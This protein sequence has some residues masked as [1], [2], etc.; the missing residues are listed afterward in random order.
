[1]R[2]TISR[3]EAAAIAH[4]DSEEQP[5]QVNKLRVEF[6]HPAKPDCINGAC[7]HD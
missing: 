1:M 5:Q 6:L 2:L 7:C 3:S 4:S